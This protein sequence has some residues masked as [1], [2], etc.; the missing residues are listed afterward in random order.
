MKPLNETIAT[1]QQIRLHTWVRVALLVAFVL[2]AAGAYYLDLQG[3]SL[4]HISETGSV[5]FFLCMVFLAA[6]AYELAALGVQGL[7]YL[8]RGA[9]G[10]VKMLTGFVRVVAVLV[11]AVAFMY[12]TGKLQ[13]I[14]A[15]VGAFAGLLL[16][17]S[18]QAPVSGMAAWALVTIKRPFRVGDRVLFPSL[19]LLGDVLEVGLM[20]TKLNQVG[21]SVGSEEAIG[22]HILIPNAMLFSQVAINY[23]PEHLSEYF[24]DEVVIRL[25]YDSDWD[26]AEEILLSAACKVTADI[27]RETGKEPYI[28]SDIYD[29]GVYMRLRYMTAAKDRPRMSHEILKRIF[30]DFQKNP[31]VDFAI[32]FLYSNRK[33]ME[34]AART[35]GSTTTEI[36]INDIED[37]QAGQPLSESEETSLRELSPRIQ[38]LGLLQPIVV[39]R[40]AEGRYKL[41]AGRLRLLACRQLGWKGIPAVIRSGPMPGIHSA[42]A[43]EGG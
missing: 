3:V 27:I 37:P 31:R 36:P 19:N 11:V 40:T 43:F 26:K 8:R 15:L 38:K 16:G 4:G 25:T 39:W 30:L 33:G 22:R 32:P 12:S 17:W 14:G 5:M 2:L 20:Y 35:M 24:L 29:Y 6:A 18:L 28:R 23:T 7:V 13:A 34:I 10:E 9:A 1:P 42:E 41:V 21:G